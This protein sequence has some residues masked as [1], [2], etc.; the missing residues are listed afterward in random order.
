MLELNDQ[1]E[2]NLSWNC[3]LLIV[4]ENEYENVSFGEK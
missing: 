2:I 1:T 3:R 4:K